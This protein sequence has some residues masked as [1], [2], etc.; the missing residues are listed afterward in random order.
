MTVDEL[1]AKIKKDVP[2]FP[3]GL[4]PVVWLFG[5]RKVSFRVARILLNTRVKPNH[6]TISGLLLF[7]IGMVLVAT[8]KHGLMVIGAVLN[9]ICVYL[10]YVDGDLARAKS[11]TSNLG[12]QLDS[13]FTYLEMIVIPISMVSALY[14]QSRMDY[15]LVMGAMVVFNLFMYTNG[16]QKIP[17]SEGD[18]S[19]EVGRQDQRGIVER[20]RQTLNM[21]ISFPV[22][23]QTDTRLFVFWVGCL[24]NTLLPVL[25][26]YV[27]WSCYEI[28]NMG[29]AYLRSYEIL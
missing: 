7:L 3:N 19:L 18:V 24:F 17:Q 20:V 11:L 10:D 8:G 16:R 21:D 1:R 29:L 28:V 13:T 5:Y 2:E 27:I 26:Y 22:L 9:W 25:V 6:I 4:P 23:F 15:V 12:K 14:I